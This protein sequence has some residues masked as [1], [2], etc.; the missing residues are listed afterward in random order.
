MTQSETGTPEA[1][2]RIDFERLRS[3]TE[4]DI[5]RWKREDGDDDAQL[6]PPRLVIP[7]PDARKVRE[8]LGLSQ[9]EFARR[10]HLSLRTLQEWEQR[11]RIPDGPAR[12]L[13][14]IIDREPDAAAR[15]LAGR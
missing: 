10:F 8:R 12:I 3:I 7:G 1:D 15:A 9:Q 6:G 2:G 4:D 13:L 14:Q 5:E 11:R